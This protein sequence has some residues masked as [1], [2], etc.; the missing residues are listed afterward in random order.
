MTNVYILSGFL[1]AGKTTYL[2]KLLTE[3]FADRKVVLIENDF[4]EVSL[5]AALLQDGGFSVTT[6]QNGCICC[7]LAGDFITAIK[8]VI[9]EYEPQDILIE[10]SGIGK[11]SDIETACLHPSLADRIVLAQKITIVDVTRFAIYLENFGEYYLDQ[12]LAADTIIPSHTEGEPELTEQ[13]MAEIARL[14]G[15]AAPAGCG[16]HEHQHSEGCGC[17]E[18]HQHDEGC[19]C[20][21]HHQHDEGCGCR[22]HHDHG[23]Q[24]VDPLFTSLTLKPSGTVSLTALQEAFVALETEHPLMVVR[25]KGILQTDEGLRQLQYLYQ[26]L[27]ITP[28]ENSG[29]YLTLIGPRLDEAV[30]KNLFS[31]VV[32]V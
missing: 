15:A 23:H 22:G 11:L 9:R 31:K 10:P 7:S 14:R 17:H 24:H 21:E 20:H 2:Q 25:A 30:I 12:I 28:H 27:T 19:G 6:L 13:V 32:P 18:H 3:H 1:G 26:R 5:D 29:H 16:C 4:G 8:A